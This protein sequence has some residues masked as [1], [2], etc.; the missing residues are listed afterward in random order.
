MGIKDFFKIK[1][2]ELNEA[3][4]ELHN[5]GLELAISSIDKRYVE[6][7]C[8]YDGCK[9][10]FNIKTTIE[11]VENHKETLLENLN[12]IAALI[13]DGHA[14]KDEIFNNCRNV[15]GDNQI[16]LLSISK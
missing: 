3:D 8:A 9:I 5:K 14:I 4:K 6:V 11:Q 1:D 12:V 2:S 13:K 10:V 16:K 15:T 7:C